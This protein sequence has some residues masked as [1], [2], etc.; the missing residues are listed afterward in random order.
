MKKTYAIV[1]TYN[2]QNNTALLVKTL[3]SQCEKVIVV[4]N[5][6]TTPIEETLRQKNG[7]SVKIIKLNDNMG[8]AYALNEGIRISLKENADYI[9]TFD[10][11]SSIPDN[12]ILS[13][14]DFIEG[15]SSVNIN[16]KNEKENNIAAVAPVFFDDNSKTY[17][18]FTKLNKLSLINTRFLPGG[19]PYIDTTF[20]ITSGTIYHA[21]IFKKLGLFI[22]ELF[23]DHVD[24][25]YCLRIAS[26]GYRI[27]VNTGMVIKHRIGD[28]VLRKLMF[29]TIKPNNHNYKRRYYIFRNGIIVMKKYFFGYPS[30]AWLLFMRNVHE[31]LGII[32]FEKDKIVKLKYGSIG[33]FHG[34][35]SKTGKFENIFQNKF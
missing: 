4:D 35:V 1:I 5:N 29:L 3:A 13:M 28:R 14:T 7:G 30:F 16:Q 22:E 24:T 15:F 10:Q 25:E 17:T 21:K 9:A 27:V 33:L 31:L 12:Y 6:S 26:A 18:T 11:D 32:F 20:V 23:I 19:N 2:P 34:I 8:I